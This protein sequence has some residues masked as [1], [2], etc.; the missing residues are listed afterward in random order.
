MF[1]EY[2]P[3]LSVKYSLFHLFGGG[4]MGKNTQNGDQGPLEETGE[5][6]DEI[7]E[8]IEEL[9]EDPDNDGVDENNPNPED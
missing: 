5:N 4:G 3:N 2:F 6:M 7:E 8:N 9:F 1:K